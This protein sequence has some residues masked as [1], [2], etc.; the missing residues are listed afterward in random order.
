MMTA[1]G[2]RHL[3]ERSIMDK[4]VERL[5]S[6]LAKVRIGPAVEDLQMGP[7]I[8]RKQL[9]RET[10]LPLFPGQNGDAADRR[11][12]IPIHLHVTA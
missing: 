10:G 12:R 9:E 3:V 6:H 8:S 7:L 4:F 2:M 1:A 5:V 11:A